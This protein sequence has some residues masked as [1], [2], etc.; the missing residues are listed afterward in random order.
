MKADIIKWA[1]AEATDKVISK[2]TLNHRG[3]IER[4][5]GLDMYRVEVLGWEVFLMAASMEPD[6]PY[7]S[8]F[9]SI[10]FLHKVALL[11][12]RCS[13]VALF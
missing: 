11:K 6:N 4:V 7:Q 9:V 1:S 10:A 13:T 3:L 12:K 2:E 8:P 5:S